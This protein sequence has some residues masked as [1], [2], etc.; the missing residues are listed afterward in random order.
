MGKERAGL[1]N[2]V[3]SDSACVC[4]VFLGGTSGT[5]LQVFVLRILRHENI[6]K[7]YEHI[8][9]NNHSYMF[10]DLASGQDLVELIRS[11]QPTLTD[12]SLRTCYK[13]I[14]ETVIYLHSRGIY[15]G[16]LKPEN[17]IVDPNTNAVILVDFGA[18]QRRGSEVQPRSS[19]RT[20]TPHYLPPEC[21]TDK[22]PPPSSPPPR[23]NQNC[24]KTHGHRHKLC[25]HH[26]RRPCSPKQHQ[27]NTKPKI[28]EKGAKGEKKTLRL[29]SS[30]VSFSS[31]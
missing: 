15:H 14:V 22:V 21:I 4:S 25:R 8:R 28:P 27:R 30:F 24:C 6:V 18:S 17:V 11:P 9:E 5:L 12:R 20:G 29:F 10:M 2:F 3:R 1:D 13:K 16:D 19:I 31:W 23:Q 7:V 26:H